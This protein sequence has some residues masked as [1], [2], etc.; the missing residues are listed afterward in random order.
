MAGS[1]LVVSES[2]SSSSS[3]ATTVA[4]AGG[5]AAAEEESLLLVLVVEEVAFLLSSTPVV[6]VLSLLS[7]TAGV[8]SFST[9]VV[10]LPCSRSVVVAPLSS[11][12]GGVMGVGQFAHT[13]TQ[14]AL[15]V[16]FVCFDDDRE[17]SMGFVFRFFFLFCGGGLIVGSMEQ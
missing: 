6:A 15:P 13:H 14:K 3:V 11:F 2:S 12:V 10:L 17:M 5:V 8:F 4:R 7:G 9:E 1:I 16:L